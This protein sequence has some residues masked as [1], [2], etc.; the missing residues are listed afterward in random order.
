[1]A[2]GYDAAS[3]TTFNGTASASWSHVTAG[4]D[5]VL[6]VGI[7][8]VDTTGPASVSTLTYNS[9]SLT[10]I[11]R[12]VGA[13]SNA[14]ELWYLLNPTVGTNTVAVTLSGTPAQA[15]IIW[16]IS[17]TGVGALDASNENG[18]ASGQPSVSVTTVA[19]NAWIVDVVGENLNDVL[20]AGG[21]QSKKWQDA[22]ASRTAAMSTLGPVTPAGATALSWS[23]VTDAWIEIAASF[24]PVA[25]G[26][27]LGDEGRPVF[28]WRL[29]EP[30][31]SVW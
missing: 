6:V 27:G 24:S 1:M 9:V 22:L 15:A 13:N 29:P 16:G 11:R 2:I 14:G 8:I 30:L 7:Y 31:V 21:S 18:A 12:R 25:A 28:V 23:G 17:L 10:L 19:D 3:N 20:T 26:A 5:R 4:A